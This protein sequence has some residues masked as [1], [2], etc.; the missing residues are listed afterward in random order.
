M[1]P[2][3]QEMSFKSFGPS[4]M[5]CF[6]FLIIVSVALIMR[7]R[8][9]RSTE[10]VLRFNRQLA[11]FLLAGT[12]FFQ[13]Y[14]IIK[15]DFYAG[16]LLP[17]QMCDLAMYA[18]I[19]GLYFNYRLGQS[20]LFY[21]GWTLSSQGVVT[22]DT[23]FD[24]PHLD[25]FRYWFLHL[26][27]VISAIY[28]TLGVGYRPTWKDYRAVC[29]FTVAWCGAVFIFNWVANANYIYMM[30]KPDADS[31]LNVFPAWPYYIFLTF[32]IAFVLWAVITMPF[33]R[34]RRKLN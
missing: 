15:A 17:L 12:I 2:I 9:F 29:K 20:I 34:K 25:F 31:A 10:S 26:G 7:V 23:W 8:R 24:F 14:K 1:N 22:P 27:V 4:H 6:A 33:A 16:W 11:L 5:L 21:W 28:L 3:A 13:V 19:A 30:H 32:G 18:A